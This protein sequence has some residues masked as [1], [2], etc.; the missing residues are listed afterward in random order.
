VSAPVV[1]WA[2]ARR[3]LVGT[4][5]C[6]LVTTDERSTTVGGAGGVQAAGKATTTRTTAL[7]ETIQ[8]SKA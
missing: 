2:T 8:L 6:A 1:T 5:L 3:A 4:W 7:V